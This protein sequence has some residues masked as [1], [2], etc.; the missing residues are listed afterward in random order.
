MV[1]DLEHLAQCKVRLRAGRSKC[2][3]GH[4]LR[5]PPAKDPEGL[6]AI[7]AAHGPNT[8]VIFCVI[9]AAGCADDERIHF[10]LSVCWVFKRDLVPDFPAASEDRLAIENLVAF[11]AGYY[12]PVAFALLISD[13]LARVRGHGIHARRMIGRR[14]ISREPG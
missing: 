6:V 10:S 11:E 14:R 5:G 12:A 8:A 2:A 4:H 3:S 13:L 7:S 1:R 9:N